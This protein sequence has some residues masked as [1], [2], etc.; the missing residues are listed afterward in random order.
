M[1]EIK[2]KA[3]A[4]GTS[5]QIAYDLLYSRREIQMR[6]SLYRWLIRLLAPQP[7]ALLLDI[8]CGQGQLVRLAAAEGLRAV[9][10]DIS[11]AGIS[12]GDFQQTQ[13]TTW[14]VG[15]G[16]KIPLATAS[17]DYITHIGSLEHYQQ[18]LDGVREIARLLKPEGTACIL[19]PNMFGL[20]GNIIHVWRHGEVFDDGQPLQRYG[21]R[22]SWAYLLTKGG[23]QICDTLAYNEATRPYN[24]AD[25]WW[26]LQKPQ[27]L[28]RLLT[29]NLLPLNLTNQFVF[30]CRKATVTAKAPYYPFMAEL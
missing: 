4:D 23:L 19:V 17:V 30:I 11:F 7:N 13:Q 29:L 5:N 1:I 28:I 3:I 25:F 2:H 27:R 15:D 8:S 9:G 24:W 20:F 6:S 21:T 22:K 12:R 10:V 14:I 26:L 16:E 18:P